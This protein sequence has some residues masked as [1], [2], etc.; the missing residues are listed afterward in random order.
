M[1]MVQDSSQ[2]EVIALD[3]YDGATEGFALTIKNQGISYFKMIAWDDCQDQRLFA[4]VSI[5]RLTF[6][7]VIDLLSA[8]NIQPI[9]KVWIPDWSFANSKDEADANDIV[10][11]CRSELKSKGF[12]VLGNNINS[13]SRSI[14]TITD[15]LAESVESAKIEPENLKDWLRKLEDDKS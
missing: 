4:A 6:F 15:A 7:R 9:S 13:E 5:A 10:V 2:I 1:V 12:L 3:Y 14:F 8:S 11:S